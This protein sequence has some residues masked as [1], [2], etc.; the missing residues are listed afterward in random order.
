MSRWPVFN[1]AD[2]SV[3]IGVLLLLF[4]YRPAE[5]A[6]TADSGEQGSP[7]SPASAGTAPIS[8][9]PDSPARGS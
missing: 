3:T 4:F 7:G 9:P 2:A 1:I 5:Q 6:D 8:V